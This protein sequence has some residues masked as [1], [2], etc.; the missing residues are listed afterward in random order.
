MF[1]T[2]QFEVDNSF[3]MYFMKYLIGC[4][5]ETDNHNNCSES[6][7]FITVMTSLFI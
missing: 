6:I 7:I 1:K 4:V 5:I 3:K 2:V